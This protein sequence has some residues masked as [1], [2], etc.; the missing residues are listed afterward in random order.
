MPHY[1]ERSDGA[2]IPSTVHPA[3]H[4]PAAYRALECRGEKFPVNVFSGV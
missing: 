1:P 2:R 4:K 3:S